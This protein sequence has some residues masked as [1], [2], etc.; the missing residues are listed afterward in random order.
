VSVS[1]PFQLDADRTS[2]LDS[3]WN[4]WLEEQAAR[5]AQDLL[6]EDWLHRF[7]ASG[8]LALDGEWLPAPGNFKAKIAAH[9]REAACWPTQ[10]FPSAKTLAKASDTVMPDGNAMEGFLSTERYLDRR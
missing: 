3:T 1:A 9:L 5:L 4:D 8:Y 2:L 6:S 7:G 10:D